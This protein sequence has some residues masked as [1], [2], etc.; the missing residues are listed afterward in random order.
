MSKFSLIN[1]ETRKWINKSLFFLS[2]F[3]T[4]QR[5]IEKFNKYSVQ[6]EKDLNSIISHDDESKKPKKNKQSSNHKK[7]D[8]KHKFDL[9]LRQVMYCLQPAVRSGISVFDLNSDNGLSETIFRSIC[10]CK[11]IEFVELFQNFCF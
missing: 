5:L 8:E 6:L 10:K 3:V 7:D 1:L 9:E 4:F 2:I 11:L